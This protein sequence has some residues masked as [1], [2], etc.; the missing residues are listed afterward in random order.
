M[1][2]YLLV[3]ISVCC[4]IACKQSNNNAANSTIEYNDPAIKGISEAIAKAPSDHKLRFDRAKMLY[5]RESYD[6]AISDLQAA[7]KIDS[8]H[9]DYYHL[10]AD[11]YMDYY[12]SRDAIKTLKKCLHTFPDRTPT[13]LKLSELYYILEQ[14]DQS[15]STINIII[16]DFPQ[17]AEAFF[18]LGLN[19]KSMGD[20]KRSINSLQRAVELDADLT[21]GWILLGEIYEA[22]KNPNAKKFFETATRSNPKSIEARHSLAMYYQNTD[23]LDQALSEYRKIILLNKEFAPAYLNSGILYIETDS[24]REAIQS[25]TILSKVDPS[26]P[27]AY[28]YL[29]LCHEILNDS[30]LAIHNYENALSLNPEYENANKQLKGLLK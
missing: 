17:N 9:P 7:I 25:F 30:T 20:T 26:N 10:L 2:D 22:D 12:R 27:K 3:I 4:F 1:K 6:I 24:L 16:R 23:Q 29:G 15:I 19:F 28:F 14:H 11:C 5:D 13:L 8:L 21:D 18:M